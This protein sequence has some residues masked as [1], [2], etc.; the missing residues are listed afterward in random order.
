MWKMR[1]DIPIK[2][3]RCELPQSIVLGRGNPGLTLTRCDGWKKAARLPQGLLRIGCVE[4]TKKRSQ[5]T[6]VQPIFTATIGPKEEWLTCPTSSSSLD[7][8]HARKAPRPMP[9][10]K[11]RAQT[12]PGLMLH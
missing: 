5:V 2:L 1:S 6:H 3:G 7:S 10:W 11:L 4:T 8:R 9:L 12:P